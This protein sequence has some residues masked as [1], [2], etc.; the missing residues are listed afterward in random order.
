MPPPI[1]QMAPQMQVSQLPAP[2]V[3]QVPHCVPQPIPPVAQ[4]P[5]LAPQM[6]PPAPK[7]P[8]MASLPPND[9][10]M[11]LA[12]HSGQ[13]NQNNLLD[14]LDA[15]FDDWSDEDFLKAVESTEAFSHVNQ[16]SSMFTNCNNCTF[17]INITINKTQ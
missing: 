6:A 2:P 16:M 4:M 15:L 5:Q 14:N 13:V 1:A 12:T 11:A 10:Q 17:N 8:C 7:R 3:S 9:G